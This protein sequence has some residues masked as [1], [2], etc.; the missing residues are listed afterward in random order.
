M[1]NVINFLVFLTYTTFVFFMTNNKYILFL[2]LINISVM[3]LFNVNIKKVIKYTFNILPFIIFTFL[4]NCILDN[5]EN[6]ILISIKLLV[7][8]NITIIYSNTVDI[9]LNS[10]NY[11]IN[12]Y[13]T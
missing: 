12:M 4:I 3:I 5:I 8:C 9:V 2:I 10:R 11:K 7:V 1:K 13:T 6:A